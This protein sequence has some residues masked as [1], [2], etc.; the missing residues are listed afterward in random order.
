MQKSK[1]TRKNHAS[2][3]TSYLSHKW[4]PD[5]FREL[6]G[7]FALKTEN[8]LFESA[9]IILSFLEYK[10]NKMQNAKVVLCGD[11]CV[12]KSAIFQYI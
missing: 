8:L 10:F 6:R 5:C 3:E 12:G 1:Q 2:A 7:I 4:D 11:V 9:I